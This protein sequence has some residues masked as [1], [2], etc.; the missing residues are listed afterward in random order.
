MK[1]G[2]AAPA[3]AVLAS[4][5]L[6][7]LWWI[8]VRSL[9]DS[10]LSGNAINF[11]VYGSLVVLMLPWIWRRRA[12]LRA[13]GSLLLGAGACFGG[14][15]A[16]WNFAVLEGHVVR[17]VLL[18][19]LA[20]IWAIFLAWLLLKQ[21]A[22]LRR[23]ATVAIGL[24]GAT[25]VLGGD[26]GGLV[27]WPRSSADWYGLLSGF[28]FALSATLT[29]RADDPQDLERSYVALFVVAVAG[30]V[31]MVGSDGAAAF[32]G[33]LL[34]LL[35]LSA[36]AGLCWMLPAVWLLFWAASRLDPGRV[37]I[38]LMFEVIA[39]AVSTQLLTD[40]PFGWREAVGCLLIMGAGALEVLP[41]S[42][43]KPSRT[44]SRAKR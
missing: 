14:A 27:P 12:R 32:E 38:L 3:A 40:E 26:S 35:P 36:L 30:A 42:W 1:H 21:R 20:P 5:L 31:L 29:R 23:C 37:T 22:T 2:T 43:R 25:V 10:G 28:L 9:A 24:S 41:D 6:W 8:P 13:G 11:L 34:A 44:K 39:A 4:A 33:E 15:L 17:A 7:G 16:L 18:F 19:Y